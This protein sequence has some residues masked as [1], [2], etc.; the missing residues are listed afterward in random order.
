MRVVDKKAEF[1]FCDNR[2]NEL[3][4]IIIRSYKEINYSEFKSMF[5]NI[6]E[7]AKKCLKIRKKWSHEGFYE[8]MTY[9]FTDLNL[10]KEVAILSMARIINSANDIKHT[11]LLQ[12]RFLTHVKSYFSQQALSS[13]FVMQYYGEIKSAI[14]L[15]D[16][17]LRHDYLIYTF[18]Y[19]TR[20][21]YH[22]IIGRLNTLNDFVFRSKII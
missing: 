18:D 13:K 20:V 2:D 9:W 16:V 5:C 7:F 14:A 8:N 1:E 17:K 11:D 19:L 22:P 3:F 15:C 10:N 21:Y 12:N 6:E 4:A